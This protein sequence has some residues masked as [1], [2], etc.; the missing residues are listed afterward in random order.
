M[1]RLPTR[2]E[3]KCRRCGRALDPGG[4]RNRVGQR[5]PPRPVDEV[6]DVEVCARPAQTAPSAIVTSGLAG[7]TG[8]ASRSAAMRELGLFHE[9]RLAEAR[10]Y[11]YPAALHPARSVGLDPVSEKRDV[12]A[13]PKRVASDLVGYAA[14]PIGLD[15]AVD[16]D[17][18]SHVYGAARVQPVQHANTK[19]DDRSDAVL[20]P[21]QPLAGCEEEDSQNHEPCNLA[22]PVPRLGRRR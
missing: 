18:D 16:D 10:Q 9:R 22:C 8:P 13:L 1:R 15:D 2:V 12:V 14:L 6:G 4:D 20:R 3:Q 7:A 19:P 5:R 11:G 17:Y 21:S